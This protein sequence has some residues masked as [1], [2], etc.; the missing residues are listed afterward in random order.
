MH[1]IYAGAES[2]GKDLCN[3]LELTYREVWLMLMS[4]GTGDDYQDA[5]KKFISAAIA[6]YEEGY[7]LASLNF[8][9][10]I[11]EIP[12][13][14]IDQPITLSQSDK[15]SRTIWIQLVFLTL[16]AIGYQRITQHAPTED[17]YSLRTLV[18]TVTEAYR[19]G[20]TLQGLK[21]ERAMR[22]SSSEQA[23]SRISNSAASVQSQW[24]RIVFLTNQLVNSA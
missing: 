13:G 15:T 1:W 17:P 11:Y 8:E 23:Q 14:D 22:T 20:Y 4:K 3:T 21:L 18:S 19:D 16:E 7:S 12:T 6:A 2:S 24:M 10:Q 5:L 9:L